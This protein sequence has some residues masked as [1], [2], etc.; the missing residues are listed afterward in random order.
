MKLCTGFHKVFVKSATESHSSLVDDYKNS[1]ANFS[2]V[3]SLFNLRGG[4]HRRSH[5]VS[6]ILRMYTHDTRRFTMPDKS[7][8]LHLP[9]RSFTLFISDGRFM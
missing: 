1:H 8:V 6:L 5:S 9:V 2:R 3:R 7:S 4:H